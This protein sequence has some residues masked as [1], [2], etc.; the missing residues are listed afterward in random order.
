M[1]KKL[2][3]QMKELGKG[4]LQA[5]AAGLTAWLATTFGNRMHDGDHAQR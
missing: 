5:L 1:S 4:L 2:K 3:S